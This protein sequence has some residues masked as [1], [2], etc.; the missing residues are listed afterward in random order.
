MITRGTPRVRE[1]ALSSPALPFDNVAPS[2]LEP[3]TPGWVDAAMQHA[4]PID[5]GRG[6]AACRTEQLTLLTARVPQAGQMTADEFR[7]AV[8]R[9]YCSLGRA[10]TAIGQTA[11]RLWNYMPDPCA[12]LSTALDRYM[13]FN[14]G[15]SAGYGAW[16]ASAARFPRRRPPRRP[17]A[18]RAMSSSCTVSP[19]PNREP[20]SESPPDLI[21]AL[22]V[23][24]RA[25]T[26]ELFARHGRDDL[27]H[28]AA[29]DGRTASIVG[30]DT[31]HVGSIAGQLD[32]T[33]NNLAALIATARSH[34]RP[35][36]QALSYLRDVRSLPH[37]AAGRRLPAPYD[38][39][40]MRS[41]RPGRVRGDPLVQA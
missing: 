32:E 12:P 22:L 8:H 33:M 26:S 9:T 5:I 30:E 29:A 10:L 11:I 19:P 27:R 21:V 15:R 18:S 3:T 31:M 36:A 28:R 35:S 37:A 16:S 2:P 38:R 14:Q 7:A 41:P 24:V 20:P 25:D 17:W 4:K 39:I 6:V 13:V 1:S 40:A 34:E 23:P